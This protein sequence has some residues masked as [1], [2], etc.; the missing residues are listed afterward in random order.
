MRI[1]KK[2]NQLQKQE[3]FQLIDNYKKYKDFNT[4]GM[5]RSIC[6]N[7]NLKLE[8]RIEIRD[9]AN[10]VFGKTFNFY[11]LKDPQTYFDLS[12]LGLE[13]TN[14]DIENFWE[15]IKINQ[16]KI[17][18]EKRIKHRNFGTYSKHYCGREDC[19]YDGLMI[20][21]SSILRWTKIHF[22]TDR[23][24]YPRKIK[25]EKIKKQR[26]NLT[27]IIREEQER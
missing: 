13:L 7:E 6:E 21:K 3:Y 23:P 17:L 4:L 15:E 11:Q 22:K 14:G 9:Y 5:Y 25:S 24:A 10:R 12:T 8:D 27:E 26:K 19:V 16:Q 2:I 20:S 1:G 18:A